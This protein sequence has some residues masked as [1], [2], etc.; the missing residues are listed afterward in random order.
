M[1]PKGL[2]VWSLEALHEN[3]ARFCFE[4]HDHRLHPGIGT[5]P[6][7]AYE[8][9]ISLAGTRPSRRVAYDDVLKFLTMATTPKG[10]ARVQPGL[11][12]KIRYFHYWSE[13]M[14][15]PQ[16][17]RKKVAVRYDQDDLGLAYARL[18]GKW[19]RCISCHYDDLK[20]RSEKQLR[21]AVEE[22]RRKRSLIEGGRTVTARQIARFFESLEGEE[23]LR[24]QRLKDL[25]RQQ[26]PENGDAAPVQT[27][28]PVELTSGPQAP[29]MDSQL[30]RAQARSTPTTVAMFDDF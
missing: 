3:L 22:L 25:A 1:D 15:D 7:E 9:G 19:V 12:V 20:G 21:I 28:D 5:T 23:V 27:A 14:R 18:A 13:E 8:R 16:W 26:I 10:V 2:A 24:T 17:E 6:A 4:I 29:C 30:E 11:G